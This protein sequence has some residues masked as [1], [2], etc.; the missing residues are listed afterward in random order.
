MLE[1]EGRRVRWVPRG[2]PL[3]MWLTTA[4]FAAVTLLSTVQ[5]PTYRAPDEPRHVDLVRMMSNQVWYPNYDERYVSEAVQRSVPRVAVVITDRTRFHKLQNHAPPA[6]TRPSF[7]ELGSDQPT[8]EINQLA[9]HP[10]LYYAF[11]GWTLRAVNE[12]VPGAEDWPFD[13][14]V[15]FLRLLSVLLVLPLPLLCFVTAR[16]MGADD[17]TGTAAAC[18]SFV[19]PYATN[20]MSSVTNDSLLLLEGSL[21]TYLLVRVWTGDLSRRSAILTGTVLGAA[22]LTKGL[23]LYMPV[24]VAGA[25]ALAAARSP[26]RRA[27]VAPGVLALGLGLVLGGWWWVRNIVVNGTIQPTA[28]SYPPGGERPFSDRHWLIRMVSSMSRQFFVP[29]YT[30]TEHLWVGRTL[31]GLG[32]A[33]LLAAFVGWIILRRKSERFAVFEATLLAMP[34]VAPLIMVLRSAYHWWIDYFRLV[35]VG[36]R[37]ML[38]GTVGATVIIAGAGSLIAHG[39]TRVLTLAALGLVAVGHVWGT[40]A[41]LRRY[42]G[43]RRAHY[44]GWWLAMVDWAPI[45]AWVTF[46]LTVLVAQLWAATFMAIC[47]H[48][49]ARQTAGTEGAPAPER[50]TGLPREKI[51][52]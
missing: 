41:D 18:L 24:F 42:F 10:P 37:Y 2:I 38:P 39:R 14:T 25:Y 33:V 28:A 50:L 45:P 9:Q 52:K 32:W 30:T 20:I 13:R 19:S 1:H 12:L 27:A 31:I 17:F 49:A 40:M 26:S 23:A 22:L 46:A 48:R 3:M 11:A 7:R 43:P 21:L 29:N 15:L 34:V 8:S 6:T 5:H 4:L 47:L 51:T 35:G 16:R 44:E 36:A